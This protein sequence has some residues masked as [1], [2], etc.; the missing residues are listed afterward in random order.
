MSTPLLPPTCAAN[1]GRHYYVVRFLQG[2]PAHKKTAAF[3]LEFCA[4][5]T[6]IHADSTFLPRKNQKIGIYG[7][8]SAMPPIPPPGYMA[9]LDTS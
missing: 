2:L 3:L 1:A 8:D 9:A 4:N 5:H 6:K 7:R